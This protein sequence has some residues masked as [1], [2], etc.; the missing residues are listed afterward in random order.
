MWNEELHEFEYINI[1]FG[2][3]S[4]DFRGTKQTKWWDELREERLKDVEA[5]RDN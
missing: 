1:I 2:D 3:I 5:E 4:L